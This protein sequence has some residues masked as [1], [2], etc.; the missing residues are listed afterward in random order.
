MKLKKL[1]M[2]E[3]EKMASELIEK[4][5]KIDCNLEDCFLNCFTI[6]LF[7]SPAIP[8][9]NHK[10]KIITEEL[11]FMALFVLVFA[12]SMTFISLGITALFYKL[13]KKKELAKD[14]EYQLAKE[15]IEKYNKKVLEIEEKE[16]IERRNIQYKATLE[17]EK[18]KTERMIKMKEYL[19]GSES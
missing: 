11:L 9:L 8:F 14:E 13:K 16:A 12:F 19:K 5:E 2:N 3:Y 10:L 4:K 17:R 18:E 7:S 6:F 15:I 1:E